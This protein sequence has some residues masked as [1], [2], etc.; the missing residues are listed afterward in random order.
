MFE[1]QDHPDDFAYP[2]APPTPPYDIAGWT[3]AYQMGVTFDRIL[4]GFDG[5]FEKVTA[6]V[7]PAPGRITGVP[8]AAGFLLSHA[9]NDS[10][11]A[12]NRMLASGEEVYWLKEFGATHYIVAKQG[13]REKLQTIANE[14]GLNFEGVAA[15]PAG[16]SMLLKPMKVGLWDQHGGSVPSGWTRFVLE[17]FEFPFT[18]GVDIAE[19]AANNEVLIFVDDSRAAMTTAIPVLK[20]FLENG[21]TVLAIG[22]STFIGPAL[23][24][25]ITDT[26]AG[27]RPENFYVPGS[28][29]Q[30]R[31]DNTNPLAYGVSDHVDFFFARSPAFRLA[32]DAEAEGVR[33]VA[34]YDSG[35]PL[36]SGWAWGQQQLEGTAAVVEAAVGQGKLFLFGPE[37]LFRSQPHGTFKFLFNGIYYGKAL[38]LTQTP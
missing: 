32:P 16:E 31:V 14:I 13:T 24:L 15:R 3:L 1:P 12:V 27:V 5:P 23:G 9:I 8:N 22:G 11:V 4:E 33:A 35:T 21:G 18:A 34:W 36:R 7:N 30:A 19:L 38:T 28:V 29:L 6:E 10:F 17:K 20:A 2:G 25:P 37:I 26:L